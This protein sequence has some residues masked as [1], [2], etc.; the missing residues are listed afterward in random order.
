MK[1][2][3]RAAD[4]RR[5][6]AALDVAQLD[7]VNAGAAGH[8]HLHTHTNTDHHGDANADAH[9]D[10]DQHIHPHADPHR[11]GHRDRHP[12]RLRRAD[13]G[14]HGCA[15]AGLSPTHILY[16]LS[17]NT[18]GKRG[19]ILS[20]DGSRAAFIIKGAPSHVY[21]INADGTGLREVDTVPGD[22][23]PI[24][25]ISADGSKVLSNDSTKVRIANADGT[26]AHEVMD[27]TGF[28]DVRLSADGTKVFFSLDRNAAINGAPLAAGLYVINADGRG[29][30]G[31]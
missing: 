30:G 1:T 11:D 3:V 20:A 16:Q 31:S 12:R 5:H 26:G 18:G 8:G 25:D 13:R 27:L 14:G 28:Y 21:V 15:H 23:A 2:E 9:P 17:A 19:S 6:A 10:A 29:C 22:W 7:V 24:V 4:G